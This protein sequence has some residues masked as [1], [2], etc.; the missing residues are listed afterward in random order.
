[1]PDP[2]PAP[3]PVDPVTPAPVVVQPV[4]PTVDL[5]PVAT[6][7]AEPL[8][9]LDNPTG[10][11]VAIP[12]DWPIDW[13]EKMAAGV[14]ETDREKALNLL[15]R[16]GD[17]ASIAN[18]LMN[19]EK[20]ITSGQVRQPLKSDAT[21]EQ[22]TAYR[23]ANGIPDQPAGYYEKI[24]DG[25][26]IGE[27]EKPYYD[28]YVEDAHKANETPASVSIALNSYKKIEEK[29]QADFEVMSKTQR[30]AS[31]QTLHKEW[32]GEFLSNMNATTNAIKTFFGDASDEIMGAKK[33][34]GTYLFNDPAIIKGMLAMAREINPVGDLMA[35]TQG[36]QL[37][38]VE[39]RLNDLTEEMRKDPA[40]FGKN[41]TKVTERIRLIDAKLK[42][43]ARGH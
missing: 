22:I 6:P 3:A 11:P 21:P 5:A 15:K 14:P 10:L 26:V 41:Q 13:R 36:S 25:L 1:M 23:Q 17:I 30:L 2:T 43:E 39:S 37:Q 28:M 34:D 42:L 18:K 12:A 24:G 29:M 9:P 4:T 35:S 31:E 20:L 40:A 32:G 16:H 33:A 27:D 8:T 19:Q 38:T 7:V